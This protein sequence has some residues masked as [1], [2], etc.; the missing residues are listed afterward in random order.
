MDLLKAE[1]VYEIK[2]SARFCFPIE[3][4][5]LIWKN[6]NFPN[7][8]SASLSLY[9]NASELPFSKIWLE[10]LLNALEYSEETFLAWIVE[11]RDY[12]RFMDCTMF[13]HSVE[14]YCWDS[15]P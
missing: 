11:S 1:Q 14:I 5:T 7:N 12:Y 9:S 6:F 4:N 2:I 10:K 13:Y 15:L 3:I 8:N